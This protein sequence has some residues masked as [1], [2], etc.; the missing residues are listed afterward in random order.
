MATQ[1]IIGVW[2]PDWPIQAALL[3][4][5]LPERVTGLSPIA[6]LGTA[7]ESNAQVVVDCSR[8]ARTA[9]VRRGQPRRQAQAVCPE[10]VVINSDPV[11][12]AREFEPIVARVENVAA[13]VEAL[14]PGLLVINAKGPVGYYGSETKALEILA[15]ATATAGADCQFGMADDV[16]TAVLATR[17]GIIVPPGDGADF[18]SYVRI[19]ELQAEVSLGFPQQLAQVW[20]ELGLCTLG[21]VAKFRASEITSRF[22]AEGGYWHGIACHGAVQQLAPRTPPRDIS[23]S[24]IAAEETPD[25]QPIARVDQAAFIARSLAARLHEN[26]KQHGL[27]CDRLKV[28]ATFSNG[29]SVQRTWR[30]TEPLQEH[31]TADRVRWQLDGWLTGNRKQ[32]TPQLE[33]AGEPH[34]IIQLQLVPCEV[35]VAGTSK[36]ALWG[37]ADE[38]SLRAKR[39]ATRVQ[40]VLG[41]EAVVQPIVVGGRSPAERIKLVAVGEEL[42]TARGEGKPAQAW[43]AAMLSPYPASVLPSPA[44]SEPAGNSD[45]DER[46]DPSLAHPAHRVQLLDSQGGSVIVTGR[47][48]VQAAP[49]TLVRGKKKYPIRSWAGPWPVDERWWVPDQAQRIARLQITTENGAYLLVGSKGRWRIEGSY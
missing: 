8:A 29:N 43:P 28:V 47:A 36:E 26:L 45:A 3:A 22:G 49:T 44:D 24:Y 16:T 37:G 25:G 20:Q 5:E 7:A 13:G 6:I 38:A 2:F 30:C 46:K 31:T 4:G 10:L 40:G 33:E 39:A 32:P 35:M 14:R 48:T 17:R 11:R 9:G 27:C 21:D 12:D 18:R 19:K 42:E 23:V 34:G 41:T 1:Q 15:D